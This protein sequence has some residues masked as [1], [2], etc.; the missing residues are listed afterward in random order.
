MSDEDSPIINKLYS[1]PESKEKT[2]SKFKNIIDD[3]ELKLKKPK[4]NTSNSNLDTK[5]DTNNKPDKKEENRINNNNNNDKQIKKV[6][7]FENGQIK[8]K[9]YIKINNNKSS[10]LSRVNKAKENIIIPK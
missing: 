7:S 9:T 6:N 4:Q 3:I 2:V 1:T 5:S 10:L 8:K